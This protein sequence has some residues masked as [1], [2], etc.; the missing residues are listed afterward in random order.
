ML[1][2][3]ESRYLYFVARGEGRHT[4][5]ET[6]AQHNEAIR[7]Q[8]EDGRDA[9]E[10]RIAHEAPEEAALEVAGADGGV[11]VDAGAELAPGIVQ[12]E[13]A[14]APEADMACSMPALRSASDSASIRSTPSF[15][16]TR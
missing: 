15:G 1:V 7:R 4:F 9:G 10:A 5:S 16:D 14:Q 2:P 11:A 13:R 12:V 8:L 3:A 6:Y